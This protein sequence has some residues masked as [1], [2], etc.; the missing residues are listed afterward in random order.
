M[1][2]VLWAFLRHPKGW[3]LP[4][5]YFFVNVAAFFE[6]GLLFGGLPFHLDSS[7]YEKVNFALLMGIAPVIDEAVNLRLVLQDNLR[8]AFNDFPCIIQSPGGWI[9]FHI[10]MVWQL[11]GNPAGVMLGIPEQDTHHDTQDEP[12]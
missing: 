12:N 4:A 11:A 3:H 10:W 7:F 1:Q 8:V 9:T 6:W 2:V 5:H